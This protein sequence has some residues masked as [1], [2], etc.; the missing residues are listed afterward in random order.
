M[1]RGFRSCFHRLD[2]RRR[3]AIIVVGARSHGLQLVTQSR[4]TVLPVAAPPETHPR[5]TRAHAGRNLGIT[6]AACRQQY[7]PRPS[8]NAVR[9]CSRLRDAA[10]LILLLGRQHQWT[11]KTSSRLRSN[12]GKTP[13]DCGLRCILSLYYDIQRPKISCGALLGMNRAWRVLAINLCWGTTLVE[14]TAWLV[15]THGV[16]KL[17]IVFLAAYTMLGTLPFALVFVGSHFA[18]A[19]SESCTA[20]RQRKTC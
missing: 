2:Y 11:G 13:D 18:E 19:H 6:Y 7:H 15:P 16:L 3:N 20:D 10:Q 8:R 4:D 17:A 14:I 12:A 5:H 9:K 1:R